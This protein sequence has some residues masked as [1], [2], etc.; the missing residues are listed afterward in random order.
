[1]DKSEIYRILNEAYF[2]DQRHEKETLEHLAELLTGVKVFIDIGASL[3]QYTYFA[4]HSV[5]NGWIVAVEPDPV[6][7]EELE[8]N[9]RRWEALSS[10]RLRP[11][12]AAICDQDGDTSFYIT[13]SNYSGGLFKHPLSDPAVDWLKIT[14]PCYRLDTLF[15]DSSPDL[16]KIDVEGSELRVLRGAQGIL[17]EGK[18]KFLMEIHSWA[19]P[20]GQ[21]DASEVFSFM[22]A[23]HYKFVEFHGRILFMK[24]TRRNRMKDLA[25]RM[26]KFAT[27][28]LSF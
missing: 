25:G 9:C 18:T 19:D 20:E 15:S 23:Y 10:N 14:V 17:K 8:R 26:K 1:M 6:R 27:T 22:E 13:N 24:S 7:Y 4:N 11:L 12:Q 21:K 5:K 3:G 2:S 16:V 28:R